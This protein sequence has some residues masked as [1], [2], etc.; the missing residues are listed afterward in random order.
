MWGNR[1]T[2]LTCLYPLK[3]QARLSRV[4]RPTK[5]VN[6]LVAGPMCKSSHA[7][8]ANVCFC[9]LQDLHQEDTEVDLTDD[10]FHLEQIVGYVQF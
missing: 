8:N 3:V 10:T 4:Q 5:P 2:L 6:R 9:F 7:S 1:E